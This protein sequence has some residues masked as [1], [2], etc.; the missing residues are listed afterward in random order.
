MGTTASE[1]IA[2]VNALIS[3]KGTILRMRTFALVF[4]GADY[5]SSFS[6]AS[7]TTLWASG[8]QFPLGGENSGRDWK[9]LE[10]GRIYQDD[11]K[12]YLPGSLAVTPIPGSGVILIGIGSPP[13]NEYRLLP[14]GFQAWT[15]EGSVVYYEGYMR[16][17]N[18]G[19]LFQ[20]Y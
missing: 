12:L 2:D 3:D 20:Q 1:L 5:D 9:L 14:E 8:L 7:G 15:V 11:S 16:V 10:Q 18:T 6:S 19:S 4:S 13:T 17:H